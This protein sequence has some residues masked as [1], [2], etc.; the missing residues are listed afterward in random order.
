MD[1]DTF[2]NTP[3]N[4]VPLVVLPARKTVPMNIM[5]ATSTKRKTLKT[6]QIVAIVILM[7]LL[8]GVIVMAL[9]FTGTFNRTPPAVSLTPTVVTTRVLPSIVYINPSV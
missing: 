5:P 1:F 4:N 9:A 6:D 2:A 3:Q 7:L 8:G